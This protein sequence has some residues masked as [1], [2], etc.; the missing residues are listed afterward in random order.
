MDDI[1]EDIEEMNDDDGE[2]TKS[3][4]GPASS[5]KDSLIA[6]KHDRLNRS[7]QSEE[8]IKPDESDTDSQI[9]RAEAKREKTKIDNLSKEI[10]DK[11]KLD[12][13]DVEVQKIDPDK[14]DAPATSAAGNDTLKS[15]D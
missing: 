1:F 13:F 7:L 10:K 5:K 2:E 9:A 4:T 11:L 8:A 6:D 12:E 15:V 3:D 14:D